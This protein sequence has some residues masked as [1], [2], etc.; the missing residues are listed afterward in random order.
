MQTTVYFFQHREDLDVNARLKKI[1]DRVFPNNAQK[2]HL[3][4]QCYQPDSEMV[5][6]DV[7]TLQAAGVGG[8]IKKRK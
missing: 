1:E 4:D 7:L 8:T 6:S 3:E 5:V 2:S